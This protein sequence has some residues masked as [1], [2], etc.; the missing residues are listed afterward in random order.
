MSEEYEVAERFLEW[1]EQRVVVSGR[2]DAESIMAVLPSG[3]FW[4]G[5]LAPEADIIAN[6]Y[7][8]RGERLEP[9]AVGFRIKTDTTKALV[10]VRFCAWVKKD[11]AWH[12]TEYVDETLEITF[13]KKIG[14]TTFGGKQLTD[15]IAKITAANGFSA[16]VR[17]ETDDINDEYESI[18]T[19]VNTSLSA[20]D[21]NSSTDTRLYECQLEVLNAELKPFLLETLPDAFRYDRKILAYGINCGVLELDNGIRTSDTI[22]V[23]KARPN[24]WGPK[25][26]PEPDFTYKTLSVDPLSTARELVTAYKQ[27]GSKVWSKESLKQRSTDESWTPEMLQEAESA[28]NGYKEELD[29]LE[30]GKQLL[31]NNEVLRKAFRLM[32][33]AMMKSKHPSW[34][35]FQFGFL[36]ANI[37][38]IAEPELESQIADIVWFATGGGKTETYL[39]L[40]ITAALHDRMTGKT[41]GITAWSRFPLRMLSLQQMQRFADA[42]AA[43]ELVRREEKI[44]GEPFSIGFFV[45]DDATPNSIRVKKT[46]AYVKWDADDPDNMEKLTVLENCP[47][48][49]NKSVKIQFESELWRLEHNCTEYQKSCPWPEKILPFYIVDDEIYRFLPTIVIGTLDKAASIG[50]QASMRGMVGAPYGLCSS[51]GH[52]YTYAKRSAR[53]N[54]CLVPD[55]KAKAENLPMAPE[56]FAPSFRLQDELHLLKDSLGA[57]DAHYEALYDGL[58]NEISGRKPKILASSATL[59][60]YQ[61]QCDVLY[62][63]EGRVFPCQGPSADESFWS[64]TQD[65]LMRRFVAVS[66]RGVTIEY[67]VDRLLTELQKAVRDLLA[68]PKTI[69]SQ[70]GVDEKWTEFLVNLYGTDV[71]YGNTLR[72][73]DAVVRSMSTQVQVEEGGNLNVESL[74]GR[75]EFSDVRKILDQL[76]V[77]PKDFQDRIHLISASSMMSHGVDVDRLNVMVMLGMPLT[78]AEFIQATARV[79]RKWPGIVFLIH[80]MARERDAGVFRLFDKFVDQGDRFIEPIPITKRSRR[81]LER[82]L[83]GLAMARILMIHEFSS[84]KALTLIRFFAPYVREKHFSRDQEIAAIKSYLGIDDT[85]DKKMIEDIELWYDVFVRKILDPSPETNFVN[86]ASRT[87]KAMTSLRDVE[88]QV[89][90]MLEYRT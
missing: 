27:W 87:G 42:F 25:D 19:L 86:E 66:P 5:R 75:T 1:L 61:K 33:K 37:R 20:Y 55:C 78:T 44:G 60:G 26:I 21:S 45:G 32:N 79:G 43:A 70:I 49:H 16:E 28:A 12:K 84:P 6:D 72:D 47:F 2:G 36:L 69:T 24:Y 30:Y 81:V 23:S 56:R 88:E 89:R 8:E 29:R 83:A 18:V 13:S 85:A 90:I 11:K 35:P 54:G 48:C 14:T 40:L 31:E 38:C 71:V 57:V 50:M 53:P 46:D 52:G 73:L 82:T 80:K 41:S 17:V 67:T 59:T 51:P 10:R 65:K 3:K 68:D 58:Q 74:T 4:L 15:A 77:P 39:G 62:R 64:K 34:R 9:C 7:G 76:E 63:R 22:G